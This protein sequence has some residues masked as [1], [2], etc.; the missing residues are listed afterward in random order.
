MNVLAIVFGV[1]V[2]V[3]V[4]VLYIYV[5]AAQTATLAKNIYLGKQTATINAADIT[6]PGSTAF[7]ISFW[8][9]VNS[10]TNSNTPT[11]SLISMNN[12]TTKYWDFNIGGTTP[13]LSLAVGNNNVIISNNIPIQKWCYVVVNVNNPFIDCYLDGKLVMSQKTSGITAPSPSDTSLKI[14]IGMNKLDVYL[15]NIQRLTSVVNPKDVWTTYMSTS[16]PTSIGPLAS[17]NV[18]LSLLKDGAVNNTMSLY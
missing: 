18:Q 5:F 13:T 9:Y 7:N 14:D 4:Y 6:K 16:N 2:I 1:I 11:V 17:Y 8:M 3:L 10:W 15:S 12:G